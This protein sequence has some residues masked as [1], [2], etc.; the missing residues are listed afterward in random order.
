MFRNYQDSPEKSKLGVGSDLKTQTCDNPDS[1]TD[2][3][4]VEEPTSVSE[5]EHRSVPHTIHKVNSEWILDPK[6]KPQP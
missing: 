3:R 6:V 5:S 4:H 2:C 1:V